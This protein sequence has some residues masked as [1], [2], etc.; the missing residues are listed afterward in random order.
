MFLIFLKSKTNTGIFQQNH[1]KTVCLRPPKAVRIS[2]TLEHLFPQKVATSHCFFPHCPWALRSGLIDSR[3]RVWH[4]C[5][6]HSS[7]LLMLLPL[8]GKSFQC[9]FTFIDCFK[10]KSTQHLG[11]TF[12]ETQ[13]EAKIKY[14]KK[15]KISRFFPREQLHTQCQISWIMD[16]L[17]H[18]TLSKK[19]STA[20][21]RPLLDTT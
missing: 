5:D 19:N 3:P 13:E 6:E 14:N 12:P 21:D 17:I 11:L 4:D 7:L 10:G 15:S 18:S 20:S 2:R 16:V 1:L 9:S 8:L